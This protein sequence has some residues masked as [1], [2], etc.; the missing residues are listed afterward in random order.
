MS[1]GAR[2][3]GPPEAY[4]PVPGEGGGGGGEGGYGDEEEVLEVMVMVMPAARADYE[5]RSYEIDEESTAGAVSAIIAADLALSPAAANT[6]CLFVVKQGMKRA[7]APHEVLL[8]AEAE[9]DAFL[10]QPDDGYL[11]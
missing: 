9:P 5:E 4:L 11:A 2:D 1:P 8:T 7:L 3:E 10:Y 6:Y